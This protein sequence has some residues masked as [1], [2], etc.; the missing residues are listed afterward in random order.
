MSDK[1]ISF[2][3]DGEVQ[4]VNFRSSTQKEAKNIG[5]T[6]FV[7]NASDGTVQGEAQGTADQVNEFIQYLNKGPSAASVSGVKHNDIS[8]KSGESSFNVK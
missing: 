4:G 6:G 8:V 3:V 5:V 1:R 7:L 2:K